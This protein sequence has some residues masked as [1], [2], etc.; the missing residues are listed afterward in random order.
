MPVL[1][2]GFCLRDPADLGCSYYGKASLGLAPQGGSLA[3][4]GPLPDPGPIRSFSDTPEHATG[5]TDRFV[6]VATPGLNQ[7]KPMLDA[8]AQTDWHL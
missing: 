5:P 4:P 7:L 3:R 1:G 6:G 8:W 2:F